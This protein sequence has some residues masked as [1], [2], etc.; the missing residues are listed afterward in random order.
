MTASEPTLAR[1]CLAEF[2]GT[3][4]LILI[5]DGAV[6]VAVL[7]GALDLWAVAMLWAFA[8]TFA[9][10]TFGYLSGAHYNP[11]VTL[12]LAAVGRFPARK[13]PAFIGC[14][15]AGA[16]TA[17]AVVYGMWRGFFEGAAA[18]MGVTIGQPG[19]QKLMMIFSCFYPNPG[20]VGT[21]PEDMSKVSTATAFGVEFLLTAFLMAVIM[22]FG[23]VRNSVVPGAN[24]APLAVGL[25]VAVIVGLGAPL[26]MDAVNP[27]R[28][29]GPRLFGY[30]AGF[31]SIAFPGPRGHEW[32]LYILAPISGGIAGSMLYIAATQAPEA[33]D[34]G[35]LRAARPALEEN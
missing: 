28:D 20:I 33:A 9:V 23:N 7:T 5:G 13:A 14:Q 24:L 29:L 8:V 22:A 10:Y 31:G 16:F 32:W 15:V 6:A 17:A 35:A 18:K 27:A 21:T 4:L 1:Q 11:A 34:V 30:L 3:F 26:T 12:S 19:S 25:A 2:L